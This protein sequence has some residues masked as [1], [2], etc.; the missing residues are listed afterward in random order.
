M[1]ADHNVDNSASIHRLGEIAAAYADAGAHVIAPSDM[2]DGRV[3]AIKSALKAR[4]HGSRVSVMSYSAKF[5]S[6]F[7]GPFRDAAHSGMSFGDRSF[8]QLPPGSRSLAIRA[9]DRDIEE[10]ADFVM[11]KPGGPYL[12]IC[13]D[14]A[15][16]SSVPVAVYHV[17]GEYA[18][19][20]H[21]ATAGAF[22]LKRAVME[23][24]VSFRRAGVTIIITYFAPRVL[25]WLSE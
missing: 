3:A 25:E 14:V 16:R 22:D 17:S 11:V 7:Y 15:E 12:D 21:A 5:A 20:Y 6:C 4:G 19:L 13:R 23:S 9:V 8:Y 1:K 10:G 2:M 24:M 18:M